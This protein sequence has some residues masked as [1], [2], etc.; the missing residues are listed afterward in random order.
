MHYNATKRTHWCWSWQSDGTH[1]RH[2]TDKLTQCCIMQV[3]LAA[4]KRTAWIDK[5]PYYELVQVSTTQSLLA[6]ASLL[7]PCMDHVCSQH[8]LSLRVRQHQPHMLYGCRAVS[9]S[10]HIVSKQ[11]YCSAMLWH[12]CW[13]KTLPAAFTCWRACTVV[14]FTLEVWQVLLQAI[15]VAHAAFMVI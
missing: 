10:L 1:T 5:G 4:G 9:W 13:V 14:L 15:T 8:L 12:C 3:A 2:G 6:I 7:H 11:L